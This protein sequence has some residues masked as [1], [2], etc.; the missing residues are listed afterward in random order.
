[1]SYSRLKESKLKWNRVETTDE[2]L[3]WKRKQKAIQSLSYCAVLHE[4]RV[5]LTGFQHTVTFESVIWV[6]DFGEQC[7]DDGLSWNKD[8]E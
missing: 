4:E 2:L 6:R 8:I 7:D 3:N 1:L 5:R